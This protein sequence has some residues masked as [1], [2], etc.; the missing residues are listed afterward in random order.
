[1]SRTTRLTSLLS[2][3]FIFIS[4]SFIYIVFADIQDSI[5]VRLDTY[6]NLTFLG[7]RGDVLKVAVTGLILILFN[8]L[9]IR[10]LERRY[11][12]ETRFLVFGNILIAM[13]ILVVISGIVLIN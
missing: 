7:S 4:L 8:I 11:L 13:L 2:L 9:L 5:I 12:F 10:I 3:L 1:M 6:R